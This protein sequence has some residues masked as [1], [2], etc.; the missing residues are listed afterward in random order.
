MWLN[1][2]FQFHRLQNETQDCVVGSRLP[3]YT[4]SLRL[5]AGIIPVRR[6]AC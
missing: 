5:P 3:N 2:D 6:A 4:G 1:A